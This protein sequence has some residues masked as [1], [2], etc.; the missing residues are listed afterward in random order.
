MERPPQ[1][2]RLTWLAVAFG[3]GVCALLTTVGADARWLAALGGEIV[4][5]GSIPSGVPYAAAPSSDWVNV[6]V[7]GELIFHAL[8][9]VG[10]DKGLLL[11]QVIAATAALTLLALGM[12]ALGAPDAASAAV[13]VL[14]LFAAA[15]SFIIVRSQLFSLVL[16]CGVLL[17]LRTDARSPSWRIWLLV[18]LTAVW[19]NLHGGVLVG[20]SVAGA[21]LLFG[22]F[23]RD[24]R[25]A[26]GVLTCASL[27]LFLTPAGGD[28]VDYYL[29]VLH[30]EAAVRGEGM[31]APLSVHAPFDVLFVVLA[32][33]LVMLAVRGGLQLWELV[34]VVAFVTVTIHAGRNS[35]W[36][37]C[38]VAAP[39]A[40]GL[41]EQFLP[42]FVLGR[43]AML[44]CS[45]VPVVF[46]IAGVL[47]PAPAAGASERIRNRAVSLAG[48][49][50]ILADGLDAERLALEGH[51]VWIANPLDAFAARDQRLY[52]DWLD[53]APAGDRL[54][55]EG[56]VILVTRGSPPD[57]RLARKQSFRCAGRD[58]RTALYVPRV[59]YAER[60][61]D[62]R[63][64]V[65]SSAARSVLHGS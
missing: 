11:A 50:P 8:H 55:R 59:L 23:R 10:G 22:R 16:F 64:A 27:A 29:G 24:P 17:L 18:P 57:R 62:V 40:R 65:A 1:S 7:L 21:Y 36:L 30:S 53:A 9:A 34:C 3:A 41:G 60:R 49:R 39:A 35:V 63:P 61:A 6:P 33:P 56:A 43:K 19:A 25:A 32:V 15:P 31:W 37:I 13:L 51:R 4:E 46:L 48:G 28:S 38:I 20:L 47:Q 58:S 42:E 2:S 12:R 54:L 5:K 14:V 45:S 52:L 44:L 26:A